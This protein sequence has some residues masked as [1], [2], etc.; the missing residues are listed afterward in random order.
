MSR[1]SQY[2]IFGVLMLG[3]TTNA[4][5]GCNDDSLLHWP[6]FLLIGMAGFLG[7]ALWGR[8]V[9]GERLPSLTCV[10]S[11]VVFAVWIA[12]RGYFSPVSFLAR[13]DLA[14]IAVAGI[15]YVMTSTT[16]ASVGW[17]R[18]LVGLQL[19]VGFVNIGLA[20]YQMRFDPHFHPLPWVERTNIPPSGLFENSDHF[21][22]FLL[23][24]ACILGGFLVAG[25]PARRARL[26]AA[27]GLGLCLG[28][29]ALAVSRT[30]FVAAGAGIF[31]LA[32]FAFWPARTKSPQRW[33]GPSA[34]G[35]L[36][37]VL[38]LTGGWVFRDPGSPLAMDIRE[39]IAG[40]AASP[41][42]EFWK[43]ALTQ[44][45][46]EP[47]VGTGS[48]TYEIYSRQLRSDLPV[49][50]PD[51]AFAGNESLQL[52]AEYGG[53]GHRTR[54]NLFADP[55]GARRPRDPAGVGG[56]KSSPGSARELVPGADDRRDQLARGVDDSGAVRI[57]SPHAIGR[58]VGG[59]FAGN[60]RQSRGLADSGPASSCRAGPGWRDRGRGAAA[61][62]R[63]GLRAERLA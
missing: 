22:A 51:Q 8:Q 49:E 50:I 15:V 30:G 61:V 17:R 27:L 4:E 13:A 55:S 38:A 31:T 9:W 7:C 62:V 47:V 53:S 32:V 46:L 44:A 12:V 60:S 52:L 56:T 43:T 5:L 59:D 29:L 63:P 40:A 39:R 57:P 54:A 21:A 26:L 58:G 3:L 10:G 6:G 14:L 33:L 2:L 28:G 24:P 16:F 23:F 19:F 25:N 36:G 48:R 20:L 1:S 34:I 11:L 41:R 37:L 45:E 42:F 35:A 18:W